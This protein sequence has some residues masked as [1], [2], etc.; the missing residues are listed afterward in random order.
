MFPESKMFVKAD[1]V[2]GGI[3]NRSF[4]LPSISIVGNPNL[5]NG[6]DIVSKINIIFFRICMHE[7]HENIISLNNKYYFSARKSAH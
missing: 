7:F 1:G 2:D 4:P 6:G 5:I 3:A